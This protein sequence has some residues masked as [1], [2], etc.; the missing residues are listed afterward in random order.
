MKKTEKLNQPKL[1]TI[2]SAKGGGGLECFFIG[3]KLIYR[4]ISN[5]SEYE[6]PTEQ[7]KK[8]G[9]ILY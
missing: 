5:T 1:F 3:N 4:A 8:Y 6:E 7:I 9:K 2:F